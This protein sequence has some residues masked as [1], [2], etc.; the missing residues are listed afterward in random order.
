MPIDTSGID[1]NANCSASVYGAKAKSNF[2]AVKDC[3]DEL[4]TDTA[5]DV[6]SLQADVATVSGDVTTLEGTVAS[7]DTEVATLQSWLQDTPPASSTIYD[8]T[9]VSTLNARWSWGGAGEPT[10]SGHAWALRNGLYIQAG[11]GATSFT[12]WTDAHGLYQGVPPTGA[13]TAASKMALLGGPGG[14]NY[15][16]TAIAITDGT[17]AW[18]NA[19]LIKL[20]SRINGY[21]WFSWCKCVATVWTHDISLE[22]IT[23]QPAVW[24]IYYDGAGNVT[25]KMGLATDML[26]ALAVPLA[27]AWTPVYTW[28][29][30]MS[31][32]GTSTAFS[33]FHW[34]RV[35][36]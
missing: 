21:L 31:Q 36:L 29:Y 23:A 17:A 30:S 12:P 7:L 24:S 18:D 22:E 15:C 25:P 11:P 9:F 34:F 27:I 4:Q 19:V 5:A 32:S 35:M 2:Q 3:L 14:T 13:W 1:V 33:T 8:D 6:A 20:Y 28:L 26:A 16:Q 10:G